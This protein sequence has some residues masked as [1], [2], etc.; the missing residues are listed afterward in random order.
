[1]IVENRNSTVQRCK[2]PSK[3]FDKKSLLISPSNTSSNFTSSGTKSTVTKSP[4]D[5]ALV[6]NDSSSAA[7]AAAAMVVVVETLQ[8]RQ[9]AVVSPPPSNNKKF[10]RFED[11]VLRN[12]VHSDHDEVDPSELWY[13]KQDFQ[14][15]AKEIQDLVIQVRRRQQVLLKS[16]IKYQNQGGGPPHPELRGVEDLASPQTFRCRKVR[17]TQVIKGV[18]QEQ[19]R[20]Q[21]QNL[22]SNPLLLAVRCREF[23]TIAQ[24][25]AIQRARWDAKDAAEIAATSTS[26]STTSVPSIQ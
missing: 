16:G 2:V 10:V 4:S 8:D 1:M 15:G 17:T 18:L 21:S 20:Q 23:S 26:T 11:V 22:P 3:T 24:Q 7:V 25:L 14:E 13:N 12:L 9:A 5:P 19:K 6:Q